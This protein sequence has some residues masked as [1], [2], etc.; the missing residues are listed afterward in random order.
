MTRTAP[1]PTRRH[2]LL[3]AAAALPLAL[4]PRGAEA[5]EP[6]VFS[7][8]G[9]AINGYDPVAYFTDG[10][11]VKGDAA[12]TTMWNGADWRFASA[13][14]Q[15]AFEANPDA[16]APQYGGYC[17][18]AVANGYTAKTDPDAWS[19]VDG[20]LYLNYSRRVRGL[21]ERDVPGH[22]AS[23]DANWPAV[24]GR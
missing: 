24:L 20:K 4:L 17:A 8:G 12:F 18:Y 21:W 10:A 2:L 16:Y 5:Q 23:A 15:A 9:A 11:P 13:A 6:A 14:N 7:G 22:V 3:L 1:Q 19:I